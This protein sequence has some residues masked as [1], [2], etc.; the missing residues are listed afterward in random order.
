M[1]TDFMATLREK[2]RISPQRIVFPESGEENIIRA[3]RQVLDEGVAQ[4]ILLG[5]AG[6]LVARAGGFGPSLDG[7]EIVDIADADVLA[8]LAEE[9]HALLPEISLKGA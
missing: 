8:E 6:E 9:C 1:A 4:P 5:N 3:A 2:A 7:I